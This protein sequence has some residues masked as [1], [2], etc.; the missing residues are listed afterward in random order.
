M[1]D[2][3]AIGAHPDDIEFGC[4]GLLALAQRR[5]LAT[6]M[7]I[8]TRGEAARRGSPEER[9]V[10]ARAGAQA[11][12]A[13][14]LAHHDWG[15]ARLK[16]TD[17]HAL[18]LARVV[19]E[20][21]PRLVLNP[22]PA[23]HHADHLACHALV[24]QAIFLARRRHTFADLPATPEPRQLLFPLDPSRA[25]KPQLVVDISA[26]WDKKASA[27]AAHASQM[28][29]LEHASRWAATWGAMIGAQYGEPFLSETPFALDGLLALI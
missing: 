6:G 24:R 26:V 21:T 27:L 23:D 10:E 19:R 13:Q 16:S 22:Y 5:G 25:P 1:L 3:L 11:L 7:L 17:E 14:L 8:L 18:E 20:H 29:V 9:L 12:G 28:P 4:G 15:D 2:V